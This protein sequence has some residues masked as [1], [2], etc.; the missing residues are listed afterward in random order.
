MELLQQ[1]TID[2]AIVVTPE[3]HPSEATRVA[4]V[5]RGYDKRISVVLVTNESSETLAIDALRA[6]AADYFREPINKAELVRTVEGLL[7]R[8]ECHPTGVSR[9]ELP[10]VCRHLVGS[11]PL[12][13]GVKSY[14]A[15]LANSQSN[16][17]LTGETG[18]GKE[19]A[20]E[21]IHKN[22]SRA[23]KPFVCI[24]CAAIPDTLMESEL[25]GYEK[26]AFTG[27]NANKMGKLRQ[28]NGGTVFL[29]EIGDMTP[30]TQ[31]KILRAI[32]S[33]EIQPLGGRGNI[34]LDFRIIAATNCDLEKLAGEGKFRQDLYFRLNVGHLHLP[35]LRERREDIP[36]LLAYHV[37]E[38]NRRLD[39]AV[40]GFVDEVIDYLL[41]YDWPG[42]V[43]EL[44]NVLEASFVNVRSG[45]ISLMD[46]P[47]QFR[48]RLKHPGCFPQG[49]REH[50][51]SALLSTDWNKSRAAEKLNWSRMTV[52]RKLTKYHLRRG[53]EREENADADDAV[54][55]SGAA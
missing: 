2:L 14:L 16:V 19:L 24:N 20:A 35:P 3:G 41:A 4:R 9:P 27:A 11:G 36:A 13:Q 38:L 10:H 28:A 34:P 31:A 37:A 47:E 43:R 33:K 46:L 25:F 29:D 8:E 40:E 49:E 1:S 52:Y 45:R 7:R 26:G 55:S 32:E 50:L 54:T 48:K 23:Q 6:G 51:L 17:L 5:V 53:S 30:Y 42:N 18:T 12:M 22:S 44:R 21:L 39:R 15:R